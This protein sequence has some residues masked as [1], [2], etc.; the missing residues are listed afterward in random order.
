[1]TEIDCVITNL[2][3]DVEKH[4]AEAT[5]F[6]LYLFG[7]STRGKASPSDLD[8]LLVFPDGELSRGHDLAE[9]IRALRGG[10]TYD[11]IAASESEERELNFIVS[12]N[13]TRI[14]PPVPD[15]SPGQLG[16]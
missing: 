8:V 13:A 7:S 5:D 16:A 3:G 15:H 10:E 2:L 1:M 6:K 12:E 14:W 9:A 11:V 4:L